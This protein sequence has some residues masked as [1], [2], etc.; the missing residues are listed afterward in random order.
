MIQAFEA[1]YG[2]SFTDK[3]WRNETGIWAAAWG[4]AVRQATAAPT[5]PA[6]QPT[7]TCQIYGHVVNACAE[8]NTHSEAGTLLEAVDA[9]LSNEEHAVSGGMRSYQVGS[10][11]WELWEDVR[12]ARLAAAPVQQPLTKQQIDDIVYECRRSGSDTTYNIV[13]AA[14]KAHIKGASLPR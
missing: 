13:N 4:Y 7:V 3:D 6:Q 2:Q 5:A 10:Q 8:C 14:I 9:L 12:K 1:H 11:T